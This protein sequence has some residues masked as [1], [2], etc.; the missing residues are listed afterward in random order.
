[1]FVCVMVRFV[2]ITCCCLLAQLDNLS[3]LVAV[4]TLMF[5]PRV[6][7]VTKLAD[8]VEEHYVAYPKSV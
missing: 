6:V 7:V 3:K 5:Y 4:A 2:Y 1:M 8:L